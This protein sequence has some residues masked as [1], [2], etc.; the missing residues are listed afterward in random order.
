M[1]TNPVAHACDRVLS[2]AM[3][4]WAIT[5]EMLTVVAQ[6]LGHRLA[7]D[8]LEFSAL[9]RRPATEPAAEGSVAV[10]P[11]HGVLAP[12]VN[13]LSD[14]SGGTT[15]DRLSRQLSIA[16][17]KPE[18]ATIV[19][20][21]DSPGGSVHGASEF[22]SK[23]REARKTKRII[24]H[25]NYEANSAA[26]WVA[27]NASEVV[28]APSAVIGSIGVFSIHEDLSAA[29]AQN[30]VK[31][32]HVAAG[33]YKVDGNKAEPL[34][35]TAHARLKAMVESVYRVFLRDV[36]D[37]RGRTVDAIEKG[38]GEGAV[39]SADEGLALGMIDRIATL[40]DTIAQALPSSARVVRMD[41]AS[42][43]EP[44]PP[45]ATAPA[46]AAQVRTAQRALLALGFS[47]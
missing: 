30:G 10:L 7:G 9:Q 33:K 23:L 34:S 1:E 29:L 4:P 28:A 14:I 17:A 36:A 40:E 15:F 6:V 38:Y 37:G 8:P 41:A 2:L 47:L 44:P 35:E 16:M 25:A 39:V 45:P 24:A 43:T 5:A 42:Q 32:T 18:I 11:I 46:L 22:A 26:Y 31:L 3:K 20:D 13:A 12:R 27:A 21:I 19:L